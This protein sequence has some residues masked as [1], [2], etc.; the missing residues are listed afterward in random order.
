[1]GLA[2]GT[3]VRIACA[4]TATALSA[5]VAGCGA[6][7]VP[8]TELTAAPPTSTSTESV[9][10]SSSP[11]ATESSMPADSPKP[12]PSLPSDPDAVGTAML[13]ISIK[14]TPES[15]PTEYL[16]E[17]TPDGIGETTTVPNPEA[18]CAAVKRLGAAF[19]NA[20]PDPNQ[21]CTQ[22][23]GGPQ[24]ATVKGTVDGHRVY[25]SFAATDGCEIARWNALE[26]ILGA[27]GAQ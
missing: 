2:H 13:A 27:A 11:T 26:T 20:Q 3:A 7:G 5:V 18:A 9:E 8:G 6:A 1:M 19:F 16:L 12:T 17:C 22:Q 10:P 14:P 23:Y 21:M 4:L 25:A 24:T 15:Q